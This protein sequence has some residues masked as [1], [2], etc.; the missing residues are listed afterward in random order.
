[1]PHI[2]SA[3]TLRCCSG[4]GR[5]PVLLQPANQP[6][7]EHNTYQLSE[8]HGVFNVLY[9]KIADLAEVILEAF[10]LT[11]FKIKI[12]L[13]HLETTVAHSYL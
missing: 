6:W 4:Q 8:R 9:I 1:M 5:A 3:C 11:N 13:I 7:L 12:A 2:V 10:Y